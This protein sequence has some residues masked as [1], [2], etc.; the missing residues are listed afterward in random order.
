MDTFNR[1]IR[2]P[3]SVTSF[4]SIRILTVNILTLYYGDKTIN[5]LSYVQRDCCPLSDKL[6][7]IDGHEN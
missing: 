2:D 5:H 6:S 4:F 3:I 7:D 1:A